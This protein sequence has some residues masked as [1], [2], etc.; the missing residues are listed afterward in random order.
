MAIN[1]SGKLC[2]LYKYRHKIKDT[3]E[4]VCWDC[5][6]LDIIRSLQLGYI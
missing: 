1:Q 6:L 2:A 3:F 4:Y 5:L